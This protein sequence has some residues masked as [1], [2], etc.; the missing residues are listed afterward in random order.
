MF[1]VKCGAEIPHGSKYCI[2][3]GSLL[4]D[5]Q[6]SDTPE[7]GI[8]TNTKEIEFSNE[9]EK[10][11]E[12]S[13]V[14]QK[15]KRF[16]ITVLVAACAAAIVLAV[17]S[18]KGAKSENV[19]GI[20]DSQEED[21]TQIQ[22][23]EATILDKTDTIEKEEEKSLIIDVEAE[24]LAIREKY[25]EITASI[26]SG[27][28]TEFTL[29]D[30]VTV[31]CDGAQLH[32]IILQA[33]TDNNSYRRSYYYSDDELIFAYYEAEDAY[34]FYFDDRE[35]IRWRYS[36]DALNAQEAVNHDLE[37]NEEYQNRETDVLA[38]SDKI[39]YEVSSVLQTSFSMS[40]VTYVSST[41]SLSEYNM[42][43]SP[44]RV[45]DG[46]LSTAWV[47]GADGQGIGEAITL[48]FDKQ[49]LIR[50]ADIRAG[51][52]KSSS[53]YDKNSR[54]EKVRITFGNEFSE[55]YTLQ[56]IN[57]EQEIVFYEPVITDHITFTIESVYAG[58]RYK[59]T[60]ISEISVY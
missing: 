7:K 29:L 18:K 40:N 27:N 41:S 37:Q 15:K 42:T 3:C 58:S 43:H 44:E 17:I 54:P 36:Q 53:L 8:Q 47:E 50:G 12:K 30:G 49:Y 5:Q 55:V 52:Q 31:Y 34:R 26:S 22:E 6:E 33:G 56:D 57:G 59:D 19:I 14:S 13:I 9:K 28:N 60:V 24:V 10:R 2:R 51:Y 20:E 23:S 38:E 48:Y 39:Q 4:S 35:M 32:A 21:G 45:I 16:L 25:N 46:D 1:C 11:I